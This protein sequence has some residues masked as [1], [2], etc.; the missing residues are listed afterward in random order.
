MKILLING[1]NLNLLGKWELEIYGYMMLL[2]I[3]LLFIGYVKLKNV[4]LLYF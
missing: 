1:L 3:V 2:E 4:E